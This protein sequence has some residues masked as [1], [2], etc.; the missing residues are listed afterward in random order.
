MNG[1]EKITDRIINDARAY[2]DRTAAEAEAEAAAISGDFEKAAEA[3]RK[4]YRER[5]EKEAAG[6]DARARAAAAGAEKSVV[7]GAK[8]EL[9]GRVY[10]EAEKRLTGL[11]KEERLA[12]ISGLM[13]R[14]AVEC[15]KEE[16]ESA[17]Y[18]ESGELEFA[19]EYEILLNG[20]D[21]AELGAKV[22]AE[23]DRL[24]GELGKKLRLSDKSAAINGGLILKAGN[25]ERNCSV[26]SLI[27]EARR[28]TETEIYRRL[29]GQE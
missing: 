27:N 1:L 20:T 9:V 14:A 28:E 15:I 3:I 11:N 4:E 17:E 23:A 2:A 24:S 29:F 6:S 19:D 8:S 5:A 21:L 25:V 13:R 26:S 7:L 12:F 22:C 16:K 18:Y 10:S